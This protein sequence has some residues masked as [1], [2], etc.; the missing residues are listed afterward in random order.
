MTNA[1]P[2]SLNAEAKQ[3]FL[4]IK[5]ALA[6]V[7]YLAHPCENV[8]LSLRT[9][10]SNIA[11]GA[12][13]E[14]IIDDNTEVL[15]YFSKTLTDAQRHY[16]SYDLEL[17]S[18]YSAVKYFEHILLGKSFT[19]Y[20][21]N[22]VVNPLCVVFANLQKNTLLNKSDNFSTYHSL[23]ALCNIFQVRKMLQPTAYLDWLFITSLNKMTYLFL[24]LKLLLHSSLTLTH[25]FFN[26]LIAET[27]FSTKLLHVF[28]I[29]FILFLLTQA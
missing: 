16:S 6:N 19:I 10:A 14:Q 26:F 22:T 8:S 1:T 3:A 2:I 5:T 15:G 25:M 17:L 20:A 23:T 12:I 18:V 7:A 29:Q 28:P 11:L 24:P 9:D 4:E 21:D 27:L 13:L